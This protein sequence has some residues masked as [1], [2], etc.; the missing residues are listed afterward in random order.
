MQ[1]QQSVLSATGC[2]LPK[3]LASEPGRK[4]SWNAEES[5]AVAGWEGGGNLEALEVLLCLCGG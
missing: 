2:G 5:L 1:S 3:M 4:R